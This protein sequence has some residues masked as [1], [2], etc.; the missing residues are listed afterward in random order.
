[1]PSLE[2]L[3]SK[4]IVSGTPDTDDLVPY[5]D[6]SEFGNGPVKKTTVANLVDAT[7][8]ASI[9]ENHGK[10]LKTSDAGSVTVATLVA[11]GALRAG[12]ESVDSGTLYLTNSTGE[13][14]QISNSRNASNTR[15]SVPSLGDN[16][17][18]IASVLV[19]TTTGDPGVGDSGALCI[20]TFDNT[21]KVYAEGAWRS[22]IT[23]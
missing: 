9:A 5:F 7:D 17:A 16:D 13:E 2:D 10:V 8:D 23:W 14:V 6:V 12:A 21:L 20:N 22:V 18:I 19:K 11:A 3:R 15:L 4:L 1:M